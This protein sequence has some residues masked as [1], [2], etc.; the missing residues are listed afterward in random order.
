MTAILLALASLGAP[1][2]AH[3]AAGTFPQPES[4]RYNVNWPSG[5]PL[6]EAEMRAARL[7]ADPDEHRWEFTLR[8]EAAIPGFAVVDRHRSVATPD[9]C[10]VELEKLA[11]RGK[12]TTKERTS[13]DPS[14]GLA[15]RET[16][17]GGGKSEFPIPAC[18]RDGL[19]FLYYLRRELGQGRLPPSQKVFF[20]GEY[21]VRLEY[22]GRQSVLVGAQRTEADRI[23]ISAKGKASDTAFEIFF[24]LDPARTPLLVRL[25]LALGTFSMELIR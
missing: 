3:A 11:E 12:R 15:T 16:L 19:A 13:F 8:L 1:A 24:A 10:S 23:Q 22:G 20:G 18:A 17:G 21:V 9:L 7:P 6:G 4:L 5:L 25:P 2:G 14:R